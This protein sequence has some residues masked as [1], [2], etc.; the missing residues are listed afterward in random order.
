MP[1]KMISLTVAETSYSHVVLDTNVLIDSYAANL[2]ALPPPYPLPRRAPMATC[3]YSMYEFLRSKKGRL[4]SSDR[5]SRRTW[6]DER[7]IARIYADRTAGMTFEPLLHTDHCPPGITDAL[8]AASCVSRGL[9]LLTVN[10]KDFRSVPGLL[11]I[12]ALD[13]TTALATDLGQALR[14]FGDGIV[15]RTAPGKAPRVN[16]E[17]D[18]QAARALLLRLQR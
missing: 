18:D 10:V 16:I 12:D 9:P 14:P 2:E 5:A 6:L 1:A 3:V 4:A 15:V 13:V 11:L 8:I 17:L 7:R